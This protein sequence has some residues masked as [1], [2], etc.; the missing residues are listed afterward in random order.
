MTIR[1]L[2]PGDEAALEAF[3]AGRA[4][5]SMFLRANLRAAGLV[6]G[7][8]PAQGTYLGRFAGTAITGVIAH[9]GYGNVLIQAPHDAA[10][11]AHAYAAAAKRAVQGLLGPLDQ[12]TAIR[13]ILAPAGWRVSKDS[14][15][16]LF[17]LDLADL[18][19]PALLQRPGVAARQ[20]VDADRELLA[21]WWHDYEVELLG[22]TPGPALLAKARADFQRRGAA[23]G[24][25][26][27]LFDGGQPVATQSFNAALP[28]IVQVGGVWT[29][30]ALRG[31]GYARAVVAAALHA[32]HA[33]GVRRA[34]L[35]TGFDNAPAQRAYRALGFT[36]VGEYA[37]VLFRPPVPA[38]P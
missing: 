17:V 29:P 34:V 5:S 28:D 18:V 2:R 16:T 25:P 37:L 9:Y 3:L 14:A 26:W 8:G 24:G 38:A 12:V 7:S 13:A 11:L 23:T 30:P 20:A 27:L 10:A 33:R 19:M 22:E 4:E 31:R 1:Q 15:E 21:G 36:P 35:F 6:D 32:Q